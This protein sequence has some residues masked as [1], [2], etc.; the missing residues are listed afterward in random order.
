MRCQAHFMI[1]EGYSGIA[2]LTVLLTVCTKFKQ[3]K[4]L[5][6][7][8]NTNNQIALEQLH[9]KE[10]SFQF[11]GGQIGSTLEQTDYG[12]CSESVWLL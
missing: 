12:K 7:T 2:Q 11:P 6:K 9:I 3:N 4:L 1:H 10:N 8:A 5:N